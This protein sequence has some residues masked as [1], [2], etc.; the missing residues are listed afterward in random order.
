MT[1]LGKSFEKLLDLDNQSSYDHGMGAGSSGS[2]GG[3]VNPV[4]D[5]DDHLV[6]PS[7]P[8]KRSPPNLQSQS[9]ASYGSPE[10][11]HHNYLNRGRSS[12]DSVENHEDQ[13]QQQQSQQHPSSTTASASSYG[14]RS[15]SQPSSKK[16]SFDLD[17]GP[18]SM[19]NDASLSG[20]YGSSGGGG[21]GGGVT[22]PAHLVKSSSAV[23]LGVG[24]DDD[25]DNDDNQSSSVALPGVKLN[26]LT[27]ILSNQE[28]LEFATTCVPPTLTYQCTIIRDKKGLDR[29]F[30]PAYYMHLQGNFRSLL[31]LT[32]NLLSIVRHLIFTIIP[33]PLKEKGMDAQPTVK[34]WQCRILVRGA[35]KFPQ[36]LMS[37]HQ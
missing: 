27:S 12:L 18:N 37:I 8:V 28:L 35:K 9:T 24:V 29:S 10:S 3:L 14:F 1:S 16:S 33:V 30:Y 21:G 26:P 22:R 34:R 19:N 25:T 7:T 23:G 36:S 6:T 4:L 31:L 32:N 20:H 5:A 17:G 15:K 2:V 13:Q 11:G